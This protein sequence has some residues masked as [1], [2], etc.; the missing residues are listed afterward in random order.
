MRS[1]YCE[2]IF[3]REIGRSLTLSLLTQQHAR[4]LFELTD[5]NREFLKP[6]FPWVEFTVNVKDTGKF[7]DDQ[8]RLYRDKKAV[9]VVIKR[10]NEIIG[11]I[12]FHEINLENEAGCIGYW[13]GE[14]FNGNGF[15]T[16]AVREMVSIGFSDLKL[17]RIEIQCATDNMKSRAIPERL[18]F[19]QEGVLRCSEKV[20]GRFLDHAVYGLLR[21]E[22]E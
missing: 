17:N 8:A 9:Q 13:L 3:P 21:N 4:S 18:G 2:K 16:S 11:M 15:M 10:A 5:R 12:D 19:I 6:W 22:A 7:I 14:E 20:N 1:S